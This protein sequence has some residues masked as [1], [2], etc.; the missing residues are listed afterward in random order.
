MERRRRITNK[1]NNKNKLPPESVKENERNGSFL[2][3]LVHH[4]RETFRER[5]VP[6][7]GGRESDG[8]VCLYNFKLQIYFFIFF[9]CLFIYI[10]K[11]FL[12]FKFLLNG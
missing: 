5:E 6:V 3:P 1:N 4:V 9:N 8:S 12:V 10:F 7:T 2:S 11:Q